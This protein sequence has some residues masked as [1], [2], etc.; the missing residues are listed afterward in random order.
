[1]RKLKKLFLIALFTTFTFSLFAKGDEDELKPRFALVIGNQNYEQSKLDNP[2][3]DAKLITEILKNNGFEVLAY[4]DLDRDGIENAILEYSEK[5]NAAGSDVVSF[6][7]YSGH[8]V[9]IGGSNYL[10][11]INDK[12]I[13]SENLARQKCFKVNDIF[14]FVKAKTQIFVLDACRNNPFA[15]TKENF[16][17]GLAEIHAPAGVNFLYLFATQA[18]KT[19]EDGGAGG[20]SLFTSVLAEELKK[21][22]VAIDTVFSNVSRSV[23]DKSRGVQTPM[24][25][26]TGVSFQMMNEAVA[27]WNIK[28]YNEQLK[29]LKAAGKS[30]ASS[31]EKKDYATEEKMLAVQIKVQ[32]DQKER[33]KKDAA[34]KAKAQKEADERNRKLAKENEE[35]K[36]T[37]EKLKKQAQIDR[38]KSQSSYDFIDVIESNKQRLEEIRA[39]AF[40]SIVA[41]IDSIDKETNNKIDDIKNAEHLPIDYD[42]KGNLTKA[43]QKEEEEKIQKVIDEAQ[44]QKNKIIETYHEPIEEEE[45]DLL[46]QITKD[47]NTLKTSNYEASSYIGELSLS[48]LNRYDGEKK[49]WTVE[50]HSKLLDYDNLIFEY[51]DIPYGNISKKLNEPNEIYAANVEIYDTM[52]RSEEDSLF[53]VRADYTIKPVEGKVS[54][55]QFKATSISVWYHDPEEEKP[56][57]VAS[58]KINVNR[59]ISWGETTDIESIDQMLVR[60]EKNI[61][62]RQRKEAI[63]QKKEKTRQNINAGLS[64][65]QGWGGNQIPIEGL[66]FGLGGGNGSFMIP[67]GWS[68]ALGNNFFA[69][70]SL[71]LGSTKNI[72]GINYGLFGIAGFAGFSFTY[73]FDSINYIRP[74]VFTEVRFD[75]S[76][77]FGV[78]T[79]LGC[80]YLY[81]DSFSIGFNIGADYNLLNKWGCIF[82]VE[83]LIP[84]DTISY[85]F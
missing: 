81:S 17:K 84:L 54:C 64:E 19:A 28:K 47:N 29:K 57:K 7:Y 49:L 77:K 58:K 24:Y 79:A 56:R 55:Y 50:V 78:K 15:N 76:E 32:E 35:I 18:G 9:Q 8:G 67:I 37:A 71:L 38:A 16:A 1:M 36:K 66:L 80:E 26:G 33:S 13:D 27:N 48:V 82:I 5:V 31:E 39:D 23:S 73:D 51:I 40:D 30:A 46:N 62:D 61:E 41:A 2:I 70:P 12:S 3:K 44:I 74:Y 53:E 6:F 25:T 4:Y 52:L 72:Y 85:L 22:N 20:N 65:I 34:E 43:A 75:T 10:V 21:S 60:Y 59:D 11:P 83:S 14:D 42:A 69:G 63:R 68:F 45:K